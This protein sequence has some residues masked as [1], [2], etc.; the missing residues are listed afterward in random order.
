MAFGDSTCRKKMFISSTKTSKEGR[1]RA[2]NLERSEQPSMAKN[3]QHFNKVKD[4]TP[5]NYRLTVNESVKTILKDH[6]DLQK[7]KRSISCK[8]V[9]A[10]MCVKQWFW[11]SDE[12]KCMITGEAN[13]QS[14]QH[15]AKGGPDLKD[16]VKVV[17]KSKSW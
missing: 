3:D 13:N 6:V 16:L 7:L 9:V 15:R 2:D 8:K 1:E 10:F 14:S 4:W 12:F 5:R 17:K 11:L